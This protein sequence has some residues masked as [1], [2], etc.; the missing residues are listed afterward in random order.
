MKICN[1]IFFTLVGVCVGGMI[2]GNVNTEK[3]S[4]HTSTVSGTTGNLNCS[5]SS[6]VV[7]GK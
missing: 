3:T 1:F 2:W 6:C 7:K 5:G 4:Q